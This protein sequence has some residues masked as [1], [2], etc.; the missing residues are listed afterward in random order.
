[1]TKFEAP[2]PQIGKNREIQTPWGGVGLTLDLSRH[3][4][5]NQKS[6]S[7]VSGHGCFANIS[8]LLPA[9]SG[10]ILMNFEAPWPQ[11]GEKS[12]IL[13]TWGGVSLTLDLFRHPPVNQKSCSFVSGHGCFANIAT[14]LPG[15]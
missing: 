15:S 5:V 9:N 7:F 4:P 8:T 2:Q 14:L 10:H 3:P 11:V 6:C 12:V 1:M 13:T